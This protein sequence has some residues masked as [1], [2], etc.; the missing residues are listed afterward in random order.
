MN[1]IKKKDKKLFFRKETIASLNN[2]ALNRIFGGE[3]PPSDT[4]TYFTEKCQTDKTKDPPCL[5]EEV[6]SEL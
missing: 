5:T 3:A 1:L 6:P 4:L 2:V